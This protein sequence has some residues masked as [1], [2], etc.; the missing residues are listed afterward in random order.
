MK[1]NMTVLI[2]IFVIAVMSM[3]ILTYNKPGTELDVWSG[4]TYTENA[5]FGDGEKT[6][7]V[8]VIAEDK[9]VTFTIH[10]DK[11]TLGEA[12]LEHSLIE[13]EN[14]AYG[15]YVK[16]VNGILAD[17]DK[18]QCY[19]GLYKNGESLMTGVD[20]VDITSGEHYEVVYTK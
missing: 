3:C 17:Y 1:K 7:L 4:A 9:S 19:W 5:E 20:G 15:L 10:S 14:G 6:V 8:E 12:M 13:G 18:N 2:S 11:K 16:K